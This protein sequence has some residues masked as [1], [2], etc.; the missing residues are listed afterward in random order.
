MEE[1]F[2]QGWAKSRHMREI[3]TD[4]RLQGM[5][6]RKIRDTLIRKLK[7]KGLSRPPTYKMHPWQSLQA[8]SRDFQL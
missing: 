5:N 4:R 2:K 6:N 7:R 3:Q 1:T 8:L